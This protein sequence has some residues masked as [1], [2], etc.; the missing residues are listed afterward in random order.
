MKRKRV[1]PFSPSSGGGPGLRPVLAALPRVPL[2]AVPLAGRAVPALVRPV[3]A[4]Q[5]AI[6]G[7]FLLERRH[8]PHPLQHHVLEVPRGGGAPLRPRRTAATSDPH[9]QRAEGRGGRLDGIQR[10][11]LKASCASGQARRG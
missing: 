6:G 11:L 10:Q 7:S 9:R 4:L 5:L 8:Q 3:R 1:S 2:P